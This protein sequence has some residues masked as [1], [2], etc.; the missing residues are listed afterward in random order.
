MDWEAGGSRLSDRK[1]GEEVGRSPPSK[2]SPGR[3]IVIVI[4]IIQWS[5]P[6][7]ERGHFNFIQYLHILLV[8]YNM[9]DNHFHYNMYDNQK[10]KPHHCYN[11]GRLC[12]EDEASIGSWSQ[13]QSA[14]GPPTPAMLL[15]LLLLLLSF[16][17]QHHQ[18]N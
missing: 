4:V 13:P 9:Y 10:E 6:S 14:G 7:P 15:L 18:E 16:N 3:V 2:P 1:R 8:H 12:S 17:G 5:T 11:P